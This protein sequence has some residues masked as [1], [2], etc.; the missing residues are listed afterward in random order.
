MVVV[1]VGIMAAVALPRFADRST[2]DAQG[3]Y[4]QAQSAVRYAQNSAI[5]KRRTVY[6]MVDTGAGYTRIRACYDLPAPIGNSC[7]SPVNS[8]VPYTKFSSGTTTNDVWVEAPNGVTLTTSLVAQGSGTVTASNTFSYNG[9][10]Q[11]SYAG[12]VFRFT[13]NGGTARIFDVE[14]DTGYVHV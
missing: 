12:Q 9:L 10:G 8:P 13:I 6:V 3:F 11:P 4:D 7:A 2:F 5:A 14:P 1:I